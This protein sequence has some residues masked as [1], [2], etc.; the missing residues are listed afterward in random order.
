VNGH[1]NRK[2]GPAAGI[3]IA[4]AFTVIE[5]VFV[6][7]IIGIIA[8]FAYPRVNFTQFQVD[9]AARSVRMTLQNA[10]RLAVT[11]Q[12]D[13]VVSFDE[14]NGRVRVFEDNNNN[15][16]VDGGERVTNL[17]LEDGAHFLMP[18]TGVNGPVGGA[19]NGA[20]LTTIDGMPSIIFRRDGAGSS[21]LEVYLTSKR[22][23][24]NDFRGITVVQSTGRTDWYKYIGAVW[25][26]GNL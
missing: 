8:L 1:R 18:P 15:N 23:L 22:N 2:P 4:A 24:P 6:V 16:A 25:K 14:A 26:A 9:A 21:D 3:P 5:L 11:R 10:Q 12:Y 19:I 20:A 17:T 7:V 13:V